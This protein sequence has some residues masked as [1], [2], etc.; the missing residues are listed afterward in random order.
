MRGMRTLTVWTAALQMDEADTR[1]HA[2]PLR[3][4]A[5]MGMY[6]DLLDGL[7][8]HIARPLSAELQATDLLAWITDPAKINAVDG[9]TATRAERMRRAAGDRGATL[10]VIPEPD[11][12]WEAMARGERPD[13]VLEEYRAQARSLREW[14]RAIHRF[15]P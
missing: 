1:V 13:V 6:G 8:S 4:A 12:A 15:V 7:R 5:E 2:E 11:R 9:G 14:A 10:L 3:V